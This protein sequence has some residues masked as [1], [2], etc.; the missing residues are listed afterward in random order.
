LA[1][2]G[3]FDAC[4]GQFAGKLF[5]A[6]RKIS[7][8]SRGFA[9][10]A[11]ELI[12]QARQA[13]MQLKHGFAQRGGIGLALNAVDSL[14]ETRECLGLVTR[15]RVDF[16]RGAAHGAVRF[17]ARAFCVFETPRHKLDHIVEAADGGIGFRVAS[18]QPVGDLSITSRVG[19]AV[20]GFAG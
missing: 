7:D 19:V 1:E 6:V 16:G 20:G 3:R 5:D 17:M 11:R 12:G 4:C 9:G 13:L 18:S 14:R 15:G 2:F 10:R 8:L